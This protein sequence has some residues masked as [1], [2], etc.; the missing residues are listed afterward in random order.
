MGTFKGLV[1]LAFASFFNIVDIICKSARNKLWGQLVKAL[2]QDK[3][4]FD[5]FW[6]GLFLMG[7]LDLPH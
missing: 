4:R 1:L 2:R 3:R 5:K 6:S 7:N